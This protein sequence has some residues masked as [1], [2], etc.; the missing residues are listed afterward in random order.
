MRG[1]QGQA[2]VGSPSI[3][4]RKLLESI[5]SIALAAAI[6]PALAACGS[7]RSARTVADQLMALRG[8]LKGALLLPG[9][10]G[11]DSSTQPWNARF[12]GVTPVAAALVADAADVSACIEFAR[13]NELSFAVR[14][15]AHSFGGYSCTT[16]LVIN[17]SRLNSVAYDAASGLAEVGSGLTNF[18]TYG[19]LWPHKVTIPSGTCPSVGVSGLTMAGGIGRLSPRDGLTCDRLDSLELVTSA[20]QIVRASDVENPDLFWACRGGGGGNF[21]A[22]TRLRFRTTPVDMP[23]TEMVKVYS[24]DHAVGVARSWQRWSETLPNSIQSDLALV[25][26]DPRQG[27]ASCEVWIHSSGSPTQTEEQF[28]QLAA[29]IGV[30]PLQEES[31]TIPFYQLQRPYECAALSPSECTYTSLSASGKLEPPAMYAKSNFVDNVWPD[32]AI[33]LLRA[34]IAARQANPVMTPSPFDNSVHLARILFERLGGAINAVAPEA[35]AF[36]HRRGRFLMQFQGRWAPRAPQSVADLNIQWLSET[37]SSVQPWLTGSAYSGY[38]DP[39]LTD[40]AQQYYGQNLPR[41]RQIKTAFDPDN[42]FRFAQSI[43]PG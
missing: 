5:G 25:T 29:D 32:D 12:S 24:L 17:V 11:F 38:I 14:N 26:G 28:N 42:V 21:G 36:P 9:E 16:G 27:G 4:R 33:E 22:V 8:R 37:F 19:A 13:E 40:W 2:G 23:F 7:S 43:E 20:A 3:T 30:K 1:D 31:A 10:D 6:A 41:L 35:T 18:P 39:M 15:G 34:A